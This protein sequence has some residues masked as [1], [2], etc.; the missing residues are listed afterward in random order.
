MRIL[1][2]LFTPQDF[3]GGAGEYVRRVFYTLLDVVKDEKLDVE[4]VAMVDSSFKKRDE[5]VGV[6]KEEDYLRELNIPMK[7]GIDIDDEPYEN[8]DDNLPFN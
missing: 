8:D 7:L 1:F 4:I 2:D 3:V 6:V 5:Y